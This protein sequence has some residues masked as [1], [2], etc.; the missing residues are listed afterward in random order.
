MSD[1]NKNRNV[2]M[3]DGQLQSVS[4]NAEVAQDFASEVKKKNF[5]EKI[6]SFFKPDEIEQEMMRYRSNKV[7]QYLVLFALAAVVASFSTIYGYIK[8]ADWFT[9][10]DILVGIIVILFSFMASEE[11]KDYNYKWSFYGYV[12]AAVAIIRIIYPVYTHNQLNSA[13]EHVLENVRFTVS[14]LLDIVAGVS[15]ALAATI[16][17]IRSR[18]LKKYLD[19]HGRTEGDQL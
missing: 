13:G 17:L 3:P 5:K 4:G 11:L 7:S 12:I 6:I 8:T 9:G 14:L 10:I 1:K 18:A 19:S 2:V 16:G 15:Y